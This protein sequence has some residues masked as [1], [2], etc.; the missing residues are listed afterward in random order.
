MDGTSDSYSTTQRE[1]LKGLIA[2]FAAK[3]G[4][5]EFVF[6]DLGWT[7]AAPTNQVV[8]VTADGITIKMQD[9]VDA[10]LILAWS[11]ATY[12]ARAIEVDVAEVIAAFGI[13]VAAMETG[14]G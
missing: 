13:G 7:W 5:Q 11:S 1:A 6:G 2:A 10:A 12:Y 8:A 14:D 9:L 3:A 4:D